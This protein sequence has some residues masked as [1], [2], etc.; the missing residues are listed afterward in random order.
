[1]GSVYADLPA[2]LG[3]E[4]GDSEAAAGSLLSSVLALST[5]LTSLLGVG[6]VALVGPPRRLV[7]YLHKTV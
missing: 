6:T 4:T 1:V 3:V 5:L 7:L 2:V